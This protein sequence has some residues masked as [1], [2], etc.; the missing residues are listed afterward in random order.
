MRSSWEEFQRDRVDPR[1][2]AVFYDLTPDFRIARRL[3]SAVYNPKFV[4]SLGTSSAYDPFTLPT[5]WP[6]P[7][8]LLTRLICQTYLLENGIAQGDRLSMASSVELRLPLIDHRLIETVIGLRKTQSDYRLPPKTWFKVALRGTLPDWVMDRPKQGF[9]PPVKEW[10]NALFEKY[11]AKLDDGFLVHAGV[12][13]PE[14]GTT[15]AKGPFTR[16]AVVAMSFKALVLE[17]WC[18]RYSS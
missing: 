14:A 17:M 6:R 8:I 9:R 5:P 2:R 11:G 10:H 16:G 4:E 18:R 7:D 1:D 12:L 15:F 3:L 13:S